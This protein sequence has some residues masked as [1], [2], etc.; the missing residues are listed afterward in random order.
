MMRRL[1]AVFTLAVIV[2]L[3]MTLAGPVS[4]DPTSSCKA[5]SFESRCYAELAGEEGGHISDIA[6]ANYGTCR[7]LTTAGDIPQSTD[8]PEDNPRLAYGM[9][10]SPRAYGPPPF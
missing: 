2:A 7:A 3:L 8:P 4:A 6:S 1:F 9:T 5:N 10:C